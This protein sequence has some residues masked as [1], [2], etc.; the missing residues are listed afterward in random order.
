MNELITNGPSIYPLIKSLLRKQKRQHKE[1][2]SYLDLTDNGLRY[3]LRSGYLTDV[4]MQKVATF[5]NKS[6]EGLIQNVSK[7]KEDHEPVTEKRQDHYLQDY[8][9]KIESEW[10]RV[11]EE[12]NKTIEY[13]QFMLSMMREQLSAALGKEWHSE[14]MLPVRRLDSLKLK[15]LVPVIIGQAV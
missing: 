1:L 7:N 10:E 5:F 14:E 9:K 2:A 3:K 11:L 6:L 8:L 12:K 4:E 13:Q 15:P